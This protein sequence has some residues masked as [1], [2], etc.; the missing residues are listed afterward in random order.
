MKFRGLGIHLIILAL[1]FV[2]LTA[3]YANPLA[4]G[5]IKI[6]SPS[7]GQRV[8]VGNINISGISSANATNHCTVSVIVNNVRPYQ[9]ATPTGNKIQNEY[10]NW[11]FTV[12]S[13]YTSIKEGINRITAKYSC[14]D[15]ANMIKHY[16]VN[17]T[18]VPYKGQPTSPIVINNTKTT[19]SSAF[20]PSLLNV[21]TTIINES[22][23]SN[24]LKGFK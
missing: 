16:S 7:K 18:G 21:N 20:P 2:L 13:K 23:H 11:T 17:V 3:G 12:S 6:T 5:V 1:G 8:P 4:H 19:S 15:N 24:I 9:Q 22:R 10:S 14:P